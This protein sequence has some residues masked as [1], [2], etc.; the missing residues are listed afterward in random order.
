VY[1]S[2]AEVATAEAAAYR[3]HCSCVYAAV[4]HAA[5]A[6]LRA[7]ADRPEVR[8]VDPAPEI[9][10]LDRTV[11][12]PPLPDQVTRAEPPADGGG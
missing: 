1:A 6:A 9:R 10:R 12:L 4:V 8:V 2:G 3:R 5:P 7:L 11:F